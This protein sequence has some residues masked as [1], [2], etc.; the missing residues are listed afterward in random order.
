MGCIVLKKNRAD[1]QRTVVAEDGFCLTG[2]LALST[3]QIPNPESPSSLSSERMPSPEDDSFTVLFF[4]TFR[5]G[6]SADGF[7]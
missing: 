1:M 4:V 3:T 2:S 7:L 6:C 5:L